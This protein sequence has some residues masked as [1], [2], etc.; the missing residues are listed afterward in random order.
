LEKNP[1]FRIYGRDQDAARLAS[2]LEGPPALHLI[3]GTSGVGKTTLAAFAVSTFRVKLRTDGVDCRVFA[4]TAEK[5]TDAPL[6]FRR[7]PKWH[8]LTLLLDAI[9]SDLADEVARLGV[10]APD[11]RENTIA[12][13]LLQIAQAGGRVILLIDGID[14]LPVDKTADARLVAICRELPDGCHVVVTARPSVSLKYPGIERIAEPFPVKGLVQ[15]DFRHLLLDR[16][17]RGSDGQIDRLHEITFGHPLAA[18]IVRNAGGDLG[19]IDY[20]RV[21]LSIE[22]R[23]VRNVMDQL[24]GDAAAGRLPTPSPDREWVEAAL[25][26]LAAIR[27]PVS[28][29]DLSRLSAA[30]AGVAEGAFPLRFHEAL[31]SCRATELLAIDSYPDLRGKVRFSH[32]AITEALLS[33]YLPEGLVPIHRALAGVMNP[34]FEFDLRNLA[35][36]AMRAFPSKLKTKLEKLIR[37]KKWLEQ[38]SDYLKTHP[39]TDTTAL[40]RQEVHD[41]AIRS[42]LLARRF[43]NLRQRARNSS[44]DTVTRLQEMEFLSASRS[45]SHRRAFR[46][47]VDIWPGYFPLLALKDD[48]QEEGI[49]LI[50]IHG[51]AAKVEMLRNGDVDLIGSTPGCIGGLTRDQLRD[52]GI[53]CVLNRS[54]GNDQIL[55]DTRGR[56]AKKSALAARGSTSTLFLLWY[57]RW[58][59]IPR[60]DVDI[61]FV[62][63]YLDTAASAIDRDEINLISTWEPFASAAIR[64]RPSLQCV[65]DS[66]KGDGVV[67]DFLVGKRD[68]FLDEGFLHTTAR[69]VEKLDQL[70]ARDEL[71]QTSLR[72]RLVKAYNFDRQVYDSWVS[73]MRF[74]TP[75]QRDRFLSGTEGECFN[76]VMQRVGE[77]WEFGGG[78]VFDQ[79]RKDEFAALAQFVSS[80]GGQ[81][82]THTESFDAFLSYASEDHTLARLIQESLQTH[83]ARQVFLDLDRLTGGP[84]P[85]QLRSRIAGAPNFIVIL[86]PHW[87][88]KVHREE[89]WV[90]TEL[91]QA[92]ESDRRII[93]VLADGFDIANLHSLPVRL[94]ALRDQQSVRYLPRHHAQIIQWIADYMSP[95]LAG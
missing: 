1:N 31:I 22:Q 76:A 75:L 32:V 80:S 71:R 49:D 24:A 29:V 83:H 57:L 6:A 56:G 79:Q 67:Y 17:I 78:P 61:S 81:S 2:L 44:A 53:L 66:S 87:L 69:I 14:C 39:R 25:K 18:E 62:P 55:V 12:I 77:T 72:N 43:Y 68:R 20:D 40:L 90:R 45:Y 30:L 37:A 33:D 85:E 21:S 10:L 26:I 41:L 84:F 95:P 27:E 86:T 19:N 51:S 93:P 36:H 23:L 46:I 16:G 13:C 70:L 35:W 34:E 4:W 38:V 50:E 82:R 8:T 3:V 94:A 58:K 42:E 7:D 5:D 63:S 48:F 65:F 64:S 60:A 11:S 52:L 9:Q 59:Q 92:L 28:T 15:S 74:Y 89:S 47:A 91:Q 88:E 73:A 54:M